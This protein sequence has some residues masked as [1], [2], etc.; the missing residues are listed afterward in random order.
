MVSRD[1]EARFVGLYHFYIKLTKLALEYIFEKRTK[2]PKCSY[3]SLSVSHLKFQ[4]M[5]ALWLSDLLFII[6]TPRHI[7]IFG[8]YKHHALYL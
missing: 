6:C 3:V 2:F 8:L 7:F 4:K 5:Y 1:E